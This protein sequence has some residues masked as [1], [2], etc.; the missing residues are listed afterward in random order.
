MLHQLLG[1]LIVGGAL[2]APNDEFMELSGVVV[3]ERDV[4]VKNVVVS[5]VDVRGTQG[6]STTGEGGE[7][8]LKL[9]QLANRSVRLRAR[10]DDGRLGYL[11]QVL[12]VRTDSLWIVVKPGRDVIVN[13]VD[14]QGGK[15]AGAVAVV[16]DGMFP[17][18]SGKT[19][20]AGQAIL[21]VP[22]DAP[23]VTVHAWKANVGFEH[24][25]YNIPGIPSYE[26]DGVAFDPSQPVRLALAP[27]RTIRV[28]VLDDRDQPIPNATVQLPYFRRSERGGYFSGHMDQA[29]SPITNEA[30]VAEFRLIPTKLASTI[31]FQAQADGYSS[32]RT[33]LVPPD[34]GLMDLSVTMGPLVPIRGVVRFED[35]QAAPSARVMAVGDGPVFGRFQTTVVSD[36]EG[37]FELSANPDTY[38]HFVAYL[39]KQASELATRIVRLRKPAE[40]LELV[41]KPAARV[42]GRVTIGKQRRPLVGQDI[43]VYLPN[44]SNYYKLPKDQQF[45][46]PNQ[47]REAI[48]PKIV[49]N[50]HTDA[51]G[52]FELFV[53]P[54]TYYAFGPQGVP[55]PKFEVFK[56]EEVDLSMHVDRP[57]TGP[58]LIR[59][60]WQADSSRTVPNAFLDGQSKGL[61]FGQLR[62]RTNPD[63]TFSGSR[64]L[65]DM[66]VRAHSDDRMID[67]ISELLADDGESTI[68]V[69]PTGAARGRLVDHD[70]RPMVHQKIDCKVQIQIGDQTFTTAFGAS[71]RTNS[72]GE[73][74]VG[75][76]TRGF[77]FDLWRTISQ[78]AEGRLKSW[79]PVGSVTPAG[80]GV[81]NLG[82]L[83][84][85]KPREPVTLEDRIGWMMPAHSPAASRFASLREEV[86]SSGQS[87]LLFAAPRDCAHSRRFFEM[88]FEPEEGSQLLLKGMAGFAL[89]GVDTTLGKPEQFALPLFKQ[90]SLALP[91]EEALFAILDAEGTVLAQATGNDLVEDGELSGVK[92]FRFLKPHIAVVP[93]ADQLLRE[94]LKQAQQ[95]E[96]RVLIQVADPLSAA[97]TLLSRAFQRN[98][99]LLGREFVY[100]R[101]ETRFTGIEELLKRWRQGDGKTPWLLAL[102]AKGT[103]VGAS[104]T[105]AGE[106]DYPLNANELSHFATLVKGAAK[107]LAAEEIESLLEGI[108]ISSVEGR[109]E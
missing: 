107:R 80:P 50:V 73:F 48:V 69:G 92:L 87:V 57:A 94:A 30:G 17:L 29:F 31:S 53:G 109:G 24:V 2:L 95:E 74:A 18:A 13:V 60:V 101:L 91:G 8:R 72:L 66:L 54:G 33:P 32:A 22:A 37:R 9:P 15:A 12:A 78:D 44:D 47:R 14:S 21:P 90:L 79:E 70:G 51:E 7:F 28:R 61:Q 23:V 84:A 64:S 82:D 40:P 68:A 76:L 56:E 65:E 49:L 6:E 41:L 77:K 104:P 52:R 10:T 43:S 83:V 26:S 19:D 97:D 3:D 108:R 4:P 67:G 58:V 59:V 85:Q 75:G 62:A 20:E 36:A 1:L 98:H 105:A 102:D 11:P 89:L 39:D 35:G 106:T 81:V 86:G 96:K 99:A 5:G 63:G 88:Q 100:L 93:D 16:T 27:V 103:V 71:V 42:H 45:P 46:D 34:S 55:P 25:R 38:C